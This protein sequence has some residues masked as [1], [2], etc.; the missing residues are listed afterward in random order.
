MRRAVARAAVVAMTDQV[1]QDFAGH[2][3]HWGFSSGETEGHWN[4]QRDMP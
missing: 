3:E 4:V 1:L 2:T